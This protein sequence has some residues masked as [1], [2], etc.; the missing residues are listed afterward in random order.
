[1]ITDEINSQDDYLGISLLDLIESWKEGFKKVNEMYGTE[2]E[3]E[4]NPILVERITSAIEEAT[5]E[6]ESEPEVEV[7]AAEPETESESEPALD[8]TASEDK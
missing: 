4:L 5:P 3:V 7:E 6:V 8:E 1:M 2:I